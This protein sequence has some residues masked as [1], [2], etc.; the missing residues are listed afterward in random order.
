[1]KK[2]IFEEEN[3]WRRWFWK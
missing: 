2:M 1:M 3:N